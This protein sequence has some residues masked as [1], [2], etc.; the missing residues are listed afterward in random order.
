MQLSLIDELNETQYAILMAK[1]GSARWQHRSV[2]D[3]IYDFIDGLD[4]D[5]VFQDRMYDTHPSRFGTEHWHA[6]SVMF[7]AMFQAGVVANSHDAIV[8]ELFDLINC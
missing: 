2:R 3:S 5:Y 6:A 8:M 4:A 1:L 7:D